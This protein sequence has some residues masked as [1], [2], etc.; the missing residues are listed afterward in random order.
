M[1]PAA[2]ALEISRRTGKFEDE[3]WRVRKDGSQF[4]AFVVIDPIRSG[5]G[6]ILGYAKITRD[7]TERMKAEQTL[8][9]SEKEQFR[10]LVQGVS[11]YADHMLD[12]Q[13]YVSNWNIGAQRI[14][15]YLPRT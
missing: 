6:E 9:K 13:G 14:K 3:G 2:G 15:G 12:P 8:K 5:S 11:D 10:L 7:L 1:I 4:W